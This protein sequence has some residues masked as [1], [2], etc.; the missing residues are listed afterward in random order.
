MIFNLADFTNVFP[1]IYTAFV[2][3]TSTCNQTV[4]SNPIYVTPPFLLQTRIALMIYGLLN[5]DLFPQATITIFN[6][7]GKLLKEMSPTSM[8][9]NG[10]FN[11]S[12][13]PAAD[14]F[15]LTLKTEKS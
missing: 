12:K 14:Y 3:D 15:N 11:G 6:R 4:N 7:Y 10:T 9:W 13:L 1:G 8:G 5:L 2:R